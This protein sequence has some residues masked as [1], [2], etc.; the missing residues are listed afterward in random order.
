[1]YF[2]LSSSA[3]PNSALSSVPGNLFYDAAL[4]FLNKPMDPAPNVGVA[5]LPP[6]KRP[7]QEGT[8]CF[9]S[10]WGKDKF[11][12]EGRYQ[13]ILKKV[14]S[15]ALQRSWT[16]CGLYS[17]PVSSV[18]LHVTTAIKDSCRDP[19]LNVFSKASP[20]KLGPNL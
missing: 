17:K 8:R 11:G 15:V 10:G 13:V 5:C 9:A 19:R 7:Q 1:M 6:P 4:L 12:K 16:E 18:M 3:S 14:S 2:K 20:N